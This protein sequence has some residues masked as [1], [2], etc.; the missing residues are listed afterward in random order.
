MKN[1]TRLALVSALGLS[2]IG[3][4]A[5]AQQDP[6]TGTGNTPGGPRVP[7]AVKQRLPL[8]N[9]PRAALPDDI[10]ALLAD[11]KAKREAFTQT[12]A[13]LAKGLATAT[14]EERAKIKEQLKTAREAFIQQ[15]TAIRQ[16]IREA[17]KAH[18]ATIQ[19]EHQRVTDAAKE[20]ARKGRGR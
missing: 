17:M 18:R 12:R 13:E 11:A 1:I 15:Q 7:P 8:P 2:L 19:A 3:L 14:E 9:R 5:W 16:D 6:A 20:Q 4:N 10:K